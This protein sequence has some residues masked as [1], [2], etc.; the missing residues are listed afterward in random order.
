MPTKSF[1]GK[2][3]D[4]GID[5][6]SLHTKDGSIGYRIKKLEII[7]TAP[8]T[9]DVELVLKIYTVPQTTADGAVDFS[10]NT[11]LA[12][13]Y[14]ADSSSLAYQGIAKNIIFDNMTFNQDIYV[15]AVD[16]QASSPTNYYLELEQ[17]KLDLTE[18][19]VATLKDIR[20]IEA[21]SV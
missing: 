10:D 16:V 4:T 7:D 12:V 5:T 2:I 13:A 20:N 6:I 1:R 14:F 11:L 15:T 3:K 18:N 17:I 21:S 8:G 9:G 19:T